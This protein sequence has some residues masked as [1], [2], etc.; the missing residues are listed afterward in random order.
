MALIIKANRCQT[1][2][3]TVMFA[4]KSDQEKWNRRYEREHHINAPDEFLVTHASILR[5]GL[6]LDLACGLGGNSIFLAE[7][8]YTV[9]AVD[10]SHQALLKLHREAVLRNLAIQ[11]IV[12]D[13]DYFSLPLQNYDL[14]IVFY[15][16][17]RDLMPSIVA[18]LKD[19]G[20]LFYATYN[21]RHVSVRPGFNKD[22]LIQPDELVQY[23]SGFDILVHEPDAGENRNISR[24]LAR[25]E[26]R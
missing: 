10:I 23:F 24:V 3:E 22:Y 15:F 26:S 12:A 9:H 25:K 16:F 1:P 14:I 5:T 21:T 2:L 4:L 20:L 8:S 7:C 19:N 17:S 6:A 11:P 18:A 13:L